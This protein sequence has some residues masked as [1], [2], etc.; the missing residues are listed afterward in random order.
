M[1]PGA[2]GK[3]EPARGQRKR[4]RAKKFRSER[5]T[6]DDENGQETIREKSVKKAQKVGDEE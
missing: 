5:K 3:V 4:S 6:A 1:V 2:V